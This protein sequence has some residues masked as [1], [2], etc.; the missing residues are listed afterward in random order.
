[1][2]CVISN[3]YNISNHCVINSINNPTIQVDPV[4]N[5]GQISIPVDPVQNNGQLE[6]LEKI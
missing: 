1:M 6:I 4:Q 3:N 5:N 2:G